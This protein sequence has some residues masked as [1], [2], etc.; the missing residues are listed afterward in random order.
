M[1]HWNNFSL[2][3]T[4][5]KQVIRVLNESLFCE[6]WQPSTF[7]LWRGMK[8]STQMHPETQTHRKNG[9]SKW[10]RIFRKY[11]I[12]NSYFTVIWPYYLVWIVWPERILPTDWWRPY[13]YE[14]QTVVK[15]VGLYKIVVRKKNMCLYR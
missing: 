7:C 6:S 9:F 11:I 14:G 10:S 1:D 15:G 13:I 8:W 12:I 3:N 5:W 2:I 4:K